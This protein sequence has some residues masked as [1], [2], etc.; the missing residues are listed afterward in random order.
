[1]MSLLL[2]LALSGSADAAKTPTPPPPPPERPLVEGDAVAAVTSTA[3]SLWSEVAARQLVGLDGNARQVGDLITVNIVERSTTALGAETDL[4]KD[5]T[6]NAQI[7]ALLG[8]DKKLIKALPYLDSITVGGGSSSNYSGGG[9]TTRDSE[10]EATITCEVI[11]VLASGTLR[12]WGYKQVRVNRE[13]Q[14]ITLEGM[15]RPRDIQMD[16]TVTSDLL[17]QAKVEITGSGVIADKQG[18]GFLTRVLDVLW[19]F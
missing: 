7:D 12:V 13:T 10:V 9:N 5:S 1:M 16:N 3:G 15:V 17:A 18:P 14:Y 2:C 19:P 11:E 8:M 6:A 4:H